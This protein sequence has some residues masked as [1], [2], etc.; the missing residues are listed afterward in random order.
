MASRLSVLELTAL[1]VIV[2]ILLAQDQTEEEIE[3]MGA[4]FTIV[5]DV[6]ELFTLQPALFQHI[7][8]HSQS[9]FSSRTHEG[10]DHPVADCGGLS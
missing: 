4:F 6:L 1:A 10:C 3:T 5:G 8:T 7:R 2:S 9:D